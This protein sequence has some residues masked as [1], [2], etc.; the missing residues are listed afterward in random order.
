ME[1]TQAQSRLAWIDNL[2]TLMIVLVVNMHACVTYSHIGSW[3]RMEEPE[4]AMPVKIVF[5]FWQGHLQAFFM[6]LLFFLAGVF[7]HQPLARRGPGAFLRERGRRLGLPS[8]LFMLLIQPFMVYV[9]LGRPQVPNRPSLATL[10]GGYLISGRFLGGSGPMWFA[11]ALLIFC[12]VFAGARAWR[13]ASFPAT[14][15]PAIAPGGVALLGFGG[16][17]VASTFLVRLVQP[18]GA[19]VMNFQLCYFPQ[20]IAAFAVGVAAGKHG[21]LEA[22]ATSRQARVAGWLGIIGGPVLLAALAVLGGPPPATGTNSYAG[23]WNARAFGLAAWEQ[24]AGLGIA[25]R[26]LAWFQHRCNGSGRVATWL[27]ERAFAVYMLHAPVLVALT[28]ALRPAAINPFVGAAL[29]TLCGLMVSFAV[30]DAAK[31]VPGLRSIL[32]P[33]NWNCAWWRRLVAAI[34]VFGLNGF[35][36]SSRPLPATDLSRR[37]DTPS[38]NRSSRAQP[39]QPARPKKASSV[40]RRCLCS[41]QTTRPC[42]GS[43]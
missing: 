24:F 1:Q 40:C 21:W 37:R 16:L 35:P 25:L 7:A 13:P 3:Y 38:G 31:R 14:G 26:L 10:Y 41:W 2:R 23:G 32:Y 22:L 5:M 18:I 39:P 33:E 17:L 42:R 34:P 28:P 11:L 43:R 20:Y 4:P 29:L 6:G 12:V 8:L 30:A 27:S 36:E 15:S 9:L 19:R